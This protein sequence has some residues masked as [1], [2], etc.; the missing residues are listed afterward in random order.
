MK[1]R[2]LETKN[3]IFNALR[4]DKKYQLTIF[5]LTSISGILY[6]SGLLVMF[7]S[8]FLSPIGGQVHILD[9]D[10]RMYHNAAKIFLSGGDFYDH[11]GFLYPPLALLTYLPFANLNFNQA[12]FLMTLINFFLIIGTIIFLSKILRHYNISLFT[13][14]KILL[15]F[16]IF[17]F[18]PVASCFYRGQMSILISFLITIFYYQVLMNKDISAGITLIFAT[19]LKVFPLSLMFFGIFLR[20]IKFVMSSLLT[21]IVCCIVSFFLFGIPTH[22]RFIETLKTHEHSMSSLSSFSSNYFNASVSGIFF[23]LFGLFNT[24]ESFQDIF[25]IVWTIIRITFVVLILFYLY[26]SSKNEKLFNSKEWRILIFSL[27]LVLTLSLPDRGSA[28]YAIFLIVPYVLYIFVL[29]LDATEK[30]VLLIS[31]I[32]FSFHTHAIYLS[33]F[34]IGGQIATIIYIISPAMCA[35]LLFLFL[36]LYKIKNTRSKLMSN[37]DCF[38]C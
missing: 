26:R 15:F 1:K 11:T 10:F 25:I 4:N 21:L 19:I 9:V 8:H 28:S 12:Y 16:A 34:I 20:K 5:I 33:N 18:Y 6:W 7:Y 31:L 24:S 38:S 35:N 22:I 13:S 32:L 23:R 17:L 29:N 36:T 30:L 37:N 3:L 27:I 14:E 2:V